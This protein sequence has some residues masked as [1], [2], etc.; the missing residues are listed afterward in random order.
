LG[1]QRWLHLEAPTSDHQLPLTPISVGGASRLL[2]TFDSDARGP[3]PRFYDGTPPNHKH[4]LDG[5]APTPQR[6]RGSD[7]GRADY[8]ARCSPGQA[9]YPPLPP[10]HAAH[11]DLGH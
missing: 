1:T 5:S 9:P 4:L 3:T 11:S 6:R 2:G 7:N 8:L 10:I